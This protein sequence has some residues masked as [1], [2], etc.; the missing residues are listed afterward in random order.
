M[1]ILSFGKDKRITSR[2]EY[3]AIQNNGQKWHSKHFVICYR[4]AQQPES[5]RPRI[6]ITITKKVDKRAVKRNLLRRRVREIFRISYENFCVPLEVVVIAKQGAI[7]LDPESIR[8]E[9]FYLFRK[10]GLMSWSKKKNHQ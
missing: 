4:E 2:A 3:L 1:S 5:A 9:I 8:D 6:G 7:E 10:I